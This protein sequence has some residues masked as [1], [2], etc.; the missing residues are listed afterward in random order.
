[1]IHHGDAVKA[2][3]RD[4]RRDCRCGHSW[5]RHTSDLGAS[6]GLTACLAPECLCRSYQPAAESERGQ[7]AL[8]PEAT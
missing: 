6:I 7:L 1:M 5:L 3:A 8:F 4:A 2:K